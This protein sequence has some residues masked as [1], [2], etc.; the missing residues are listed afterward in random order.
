MH[1]RAD[2]GRGQMQ[3]CAVR[4]DSYM[5]KYAEPG[6]SLVGVELMVWLRFHEV[7]I[8]TRACI[9]VNHVGTVV[10]CFFFLSLEPENESL[11]LRL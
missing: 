2:A 10:S 7:C 1:L 9:I 4:R 6:T 3:T 5:R 8:V 11:R